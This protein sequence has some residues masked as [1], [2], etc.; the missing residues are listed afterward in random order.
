EQLT[1]ALS[2]QDLTFGCVTARADDKQV[3]VLVVDDS[4]ER[5]R[6]RPISLHLDP[7]SA[8]EPVTGLSGGAGRGDLRPVWWESTASVS[9]QPEAGG[10]RS[11]ADTRASRRS[12]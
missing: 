7:R 9:P 5:A 10:S 3:T 12:G 11:H 8:G 6:H 2:D 1:R 4:L